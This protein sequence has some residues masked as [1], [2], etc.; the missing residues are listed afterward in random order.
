M[1]STIGQQHLKLKDLVSWFEIPVYDIHRATAFYNAIYGIEMEVAVNG[2]FAMAYFPAE[3]GVGGAL[4]AGP[5]CV[6]NDTGTLI[7][8]N[9]GNDLEGIQGRVDLAGGRVIMPKTLISEA[10]GW[11]ALFI[12]SEGNRVALHEGPSRRQ[13]TPPRTSRPKAAAKA[14]ARARVPRKAAPG[15]P[16]RKR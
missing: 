14:P 5:G 16:R 15:K 13:G 3:K 7:Y 4:I 11:F 10:A 12:D 1:G 9:A 2:E 6:P 8:L